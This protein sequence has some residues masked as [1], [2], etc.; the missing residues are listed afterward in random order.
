MATVVSLIV[1]SV[2]YRKI[3]LRLLSV[4]CLTYELMHFFKLALPVDPVQTNSKVSAICHVRQ[5]CLASDMAS[6]ASRSHLTAITYV[7]S[8]FK[9]NDWQPMLSYQNAEPR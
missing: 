5:Q 7:V 2:I 8:A 9:T 1:V 6:G 3:T 4:E